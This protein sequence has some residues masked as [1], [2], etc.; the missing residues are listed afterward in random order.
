M[1]KN[2]SNHV[3]IY[4]YILQTLVIPAFEALVPLDGLP[5]NKTE[6]LQL[7]DHGKVVGYR[8]NRK[9]NLGHKPTDYPKW[10][11]SNIPYKVYHNSYT[12]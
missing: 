5:I 1:L 7:M 12:Y 9:W 2:T 4:I 8:M 10:V 3:Y 11:K 6:L